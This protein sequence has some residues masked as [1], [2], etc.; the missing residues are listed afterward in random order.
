MQN[1]FALFLALPLLLAACQ[2]QTTPT[3]TPTPAPSPA[4]NRLDF[5]IEPNVRVGLIKA[6]DATRETV[7]AAYGNLARVDSVYLYEG[8]QDEG[9]VLFPDEPRRTAYLYWDKAMDTRRPAFIRILGDSTGTTEWKTTDGLTIGTPI[10]EVERLNGKP[11]M[12]SGFGWDYGGMVT[13]WQGGKFNGALGLAFSPATDKPSADRI[14]GEGGHPSNDPDIRAAEPRIVRLDVRFLAH[15]T[16]PACIDEKVKAA[17]D[18]PQIIVRKM[19]VQG[20][21][22]YWVSDGAAAYDG[23]EY[24]YD[25]DCQEKCRVGGMRQ[26]L[27]CSKA[28]EGGTW[29]VVWEKM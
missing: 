3:P 20:A 15:E 23:I 17:T 6:A 25:A 19:T 7:L 13:D 14:L 4:D 10:A 27:E 2:P 26:A 21:D 16:L 9:V 5:T 1:R 22:H 8:V 24:I 12:I 28:Y 11:F 29:E 18:K